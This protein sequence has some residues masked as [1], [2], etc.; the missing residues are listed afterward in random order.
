VAVSEAGRIE[1]DGL[2]E[3]V[4]GDEVDGGEGGAMGGGGGG[5]GSLRR[6]RGPGA[7]R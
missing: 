7:G 6:P 3:E 5:G 1:T 2:G 4:S